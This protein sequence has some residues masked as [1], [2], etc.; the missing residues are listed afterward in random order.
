MAILDQA[1]QSARTMPY[2]YAEARLLYT[3]GF[4]YIRIGEQE[5]GRRCLDEARAAFERLGALWPPL[6]PDF[7]SILDTPSTAVRRQDGTFPAG[8]IRS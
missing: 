4:L 3:A 8:S 5:Q 2:P 1:L 7:V 6:S